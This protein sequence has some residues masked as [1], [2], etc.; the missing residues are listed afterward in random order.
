MCCSRLRSQVGLDV[1]GVTLNAR[2]LRA[3]LGNRLGAT[4]HDPADAAQARRRGLQRYL[5]RGHNPE[6][7]IAAVARRL[8]YTIYVDIHSVDS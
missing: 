1:V 4:A 8:V 7:P 3:H 2:E 6:G 5:L